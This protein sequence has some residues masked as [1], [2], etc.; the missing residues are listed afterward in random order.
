MSV[1]VVLEAM[2]IVAYIVIVSSG[3]QRR[4]AGWKVLAG[5]HIVCAAFLCAAMSIIV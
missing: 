5:L 4:E 1:A 3:K 2:T